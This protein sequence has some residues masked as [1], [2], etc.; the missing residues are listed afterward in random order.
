MAPVVWHRSAPLLSFGAVVIGGLIAWTLAY[1]GVD[2]WGL[3]VGVLVSVILSVV[4]ARRAASPRSMFSDGW[5]RVRVH[6]LDLADPVVGC[7]LFA[8]R[9]HRPSYRRL[10]FIQGIN[11]DRASA[12]RLIETA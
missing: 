2:A 9:H 8:L 7:R 3:V 4:G 5:L 10:T 12:S 6:P 1:S 11:P